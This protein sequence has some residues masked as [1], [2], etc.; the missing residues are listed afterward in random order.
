LQYDRSI[1]EQYAYADYYNHKHYVKP[2]VK[3]KKKGIATLEKMLIIDDT[4]AK[5]RLNF[6]NAIYPSEFNG[7]PL[8]DELAKLSDYLE[9]L[10][11]SENVRAIEKRNWRQNDN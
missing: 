1:L 2:L 4:P 5:S 9:T 7:N 11:S 3:V 6:G 10:K 8:D